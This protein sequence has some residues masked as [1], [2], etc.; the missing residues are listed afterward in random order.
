MTNENDLDTFRK[1]I[2]EIDDKILSLA[3]ERMKYV[4]KVGEYKQEN[5][6]PIK[7]YKVEKQILETAR[8]KAKSLGI[9]GEM[10]ESL[11]KELI[12]YSVIEQDELKKP[13]FPSTDP[14]HKTFGIIGGLGHMGT[15][16]SGFEETG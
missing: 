7:D 1:K 12:K 13:F 3:S 6:L 2:R 9:Y 4:R 11:L 5:N 15:W 8:K 14:E 10:A 16:L